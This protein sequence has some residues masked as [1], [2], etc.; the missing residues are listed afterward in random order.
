MNEEAIC[1][2]AEYDWGIHNELFDRM[3]VGEIWS[4]I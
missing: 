4:E 1:T 3:F 2:S